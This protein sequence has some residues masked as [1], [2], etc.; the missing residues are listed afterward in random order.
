MCLNFRNRDTGRLYPWVF[1]VAGERKTYSGSGTVVLDNADAVLRSA[2]AG[3]D[4]SQMPLYL[5]KEAISAGTLIEV[6]RHYR[7]PEIPIWICYLDR[8]FVAA[9]IRSFVKFM[10]DRKEAFT[11]RCVV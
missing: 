5:V 6:L 2:I 8:C 7:P 9:R 11:E 3:L 4:L 10:T 1:D